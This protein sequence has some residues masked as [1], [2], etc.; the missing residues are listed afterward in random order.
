MVQ[1]MTNFLPTFSNIKEELSIEGPLIGITARQLV[2][3]LLLFF[4]QNFSSGIQNLF[5]AFS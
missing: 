4:L 2:L 5:F 1:S 3:S